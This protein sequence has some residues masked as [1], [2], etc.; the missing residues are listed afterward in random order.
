MLYVG[1]V[2]CL[3]TL[4]QLEISFSFLRN[5]KLTNVLFLT[6]TRLK[7]VGIDQVRV[8]LKYKHAFTAHRIG[9]VGWLGSLM[10]FCIGMVISL[11]L[12]F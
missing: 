9:L 8:K 1:T 11:C 5:E 6:E 3:G 2:E 10:A 7:E 12:W 4:G